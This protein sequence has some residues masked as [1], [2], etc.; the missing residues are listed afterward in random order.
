MRGKSERR[1]E[2]VKYRGGGRERGGKEEYKGR[3]RGR[4]V[5]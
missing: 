2:E 4:G 1:E 3:L 5:R